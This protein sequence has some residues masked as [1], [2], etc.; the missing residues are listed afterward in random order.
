MMHAMTTINVEGD[1]NAWRVEL[2][3]SG[4]KDVVYMAAD[5]GVPKVIGLPTAPAGVGRHVLR[6]L[7]K[8]DDAAIRLLDWALADRIRH[9]E[10]SRIWGGAFPKDTVHTTLAAS[11]LAA[12]PDQEIS[13]GT[14]CGMTTAD[15][16][17]VCDLMVARGMRARK[18]WPELEAFAATWAARSPAVSVDTRDLASA[19]SR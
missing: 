3:I 5:R 16:Q 15:G 4:K 11:L 1:A 19:R 6:L 9:S 13:A 10:L 14:A 18:K 17:M 12:D 7:G 2:Q 8:H